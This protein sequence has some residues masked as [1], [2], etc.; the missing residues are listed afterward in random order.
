MWQKVS[1]RDYVIDYIGKPGPM[2]SGDL[3]RLMFVNGEA[4]LEQDPRQ[5]TGIKLFAACSIPLFSVIPY[6]L[7]SSRVKRTA[8]N[9]VTLGC[10]VRT[11]SSSNNY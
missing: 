2:N 8:Q 6:F 10:V 5:L 11:E 7:I 9:L 1:K 3:G 4:I